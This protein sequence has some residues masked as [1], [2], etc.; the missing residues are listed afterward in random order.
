MYNIVIPVDF[1]YREEDIFN[2]LLKFIKILKN[3]KIKLIF[4]CAKRNKIQEK[5]LSNVV[6]NIKNFFLFFNLET[7]NYVELAKLRNIGVIKCTDDTIIFCDAD[8]FPDIKLFNYLASRVKN[9]NFSILP[10]LYLK[11]E[12]FPSNK[13]KIFFQK[14]YIQH[15]AIPSFVMSFK[16]K[17]FFR[18]GGLHEG[19]HGHGYE[20]FEFLIKL[21]F[22]YKKIKNTHDLLV[23]KTYKNALFAEGFRA[24]LGKLCINNLLNNKIAHHI[25]H[26]KNRFNFYYLRRYFNK[27]LFKIRM[28][29]YLSRYKK[30]KTYNCKY[31]I[32][33]EI[34]LSN[35]KKFKHLKFFS[36]LFNNS[37]I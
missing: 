18:I 37:K 23:D 14:N 4:V 35:K 10:T 1:K 36:Y 13:K 16:R 15:I 8:I 20:D 27:F 31:P 11:K 29:A 34:F 3:T 32:Y 7:R 12:I 33:K 6:K 2:K 21:S 17:D 22:L 24:H 30:L 9:D 19:Y 25:Y 5:K 28:K 26:K